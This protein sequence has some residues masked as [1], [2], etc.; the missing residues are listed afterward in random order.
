MRS[1]PSGIHIEILVGY[2]TSSRN[3][4]RYQNAKLQ[5]VAA[6]EKPQNTSL[7]NHCGRHASPIWILY[8]QLLDLESNIVV[9]VKNQDSSPRIDV[10]H[11]PLPRSDNVRDNSIVRAANPDFL[12]PIPQD[13]RMPPRAPPYPE[14]PEYNPQMPEIGWNSHQSGPVPYQMP[15]A[16]PGKTSH[17][18]NHK[19]NGLQVPEAEISS[20]PDGSYPKIQNYYGENYRQSMEIPTWVNAHQDDLRYPARLTPDTSYNNN[21]RGMPPDQSKTTAWTDGR[22]NPEHIQIKM[23]HEL[24]HSKESHS[25]ETHQDTPKIK[26]IE[27]PTEQKHDDYPDVVAYKMDGNDGVAQTP[28]GAVLSLTLGLIITCIMAVMIGCRLRILKRRVRKGAKGYAHDA[29][30]L[31]NGMYL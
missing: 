5:N 17:I 4:S 28:G 3:G 8:L 21:N 26:I 18:F 11:A 27:K 16:Y 9:N 14:P 15:P 29:D 1:T 19:E 20:Y 12:R 22:E 6:S 23:A 13:Q 31:V 10:Y 25:T 24:K 7:A 2:G 30:Y